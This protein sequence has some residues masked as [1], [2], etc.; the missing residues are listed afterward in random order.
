MKKR[1]WGKIFRDK[2]NKRINFFCKSLLSYDSYMLVTIVTLYKLGICL[3]LLLPFHREKL[4]CLYRFNF[5][6][7]NPYCVDFFPLCFSSC[8]LLGNILIHEALG[9]RQLN[10]VS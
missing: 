8:C 6:D 10:S 7:K 5:G 1:I 3:A 9:L 2:I 4:M